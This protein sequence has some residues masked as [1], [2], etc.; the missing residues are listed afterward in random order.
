MEGEG[1]QGGGGGDERGGGGWPRARV[2]PPRARPA[3]PRSL[4]LLSPLSPFPHLDRGGVAL[5]PDDLPNQTGPAH[6]DQLVH[7]GAAHVVGDDDG[8]G[9][10]ADEAATKWRGGERK[11]V[12]ER[13]EARG[14]SRVARWRACLGRACGR[15]CA[16]GRTQGGGRGG[17]GAQRRSVGE[18]GRGEREIGV[19]PPAIHS[20]PPPPL[21]LSPPTHPCSRSPSSRSW[22][23]VGVY[24]GVCGCVGVREGAPLKVSQGAR[25]GGGCGAR[26]RGFFFYAFAASTALP[27]APSQPPCCSPRAPRRA[28]GSVFPWRRHAHIHTLS[29]HPNTTHTQ[30]SH[31][32]SCP[33]SRPPPWPPARPPPCPFSGAAPASF[34]PVWPAPWV[35]WRP[36]PPW[37]CAWRPLF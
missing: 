34:W 11:G 21:R 22:T 30:L 25:K 28:R 10:P 1:R 18:M 3:A 19:P 36:A 17:P 26:A 20:A 24:V 29:C 31:I 33:F 14:G 7:G 27:L 5:Q 13:G 8:A 2:S 16:L 37:P 4:L 35:F 15:V 12:D 32:I 6:P 23:I 9:D